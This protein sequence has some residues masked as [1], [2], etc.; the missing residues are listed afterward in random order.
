MQNYT[1]SFPAESCSSGLDAAE[2]RKA[3]VLSTMGLQ[4][5]CNRAMVANKSVREEAHRAEV[6]QEEP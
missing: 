3:L 2:R 1:P 5:S 6:L 4:S